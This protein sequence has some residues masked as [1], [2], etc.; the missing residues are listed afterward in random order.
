MFKV[1]YGRTLMCNVTWKCGIVNYGR[2]DHMYRHFKVQTFSRV[3]ILQTN[4]QCANKKNISIENVI[5]KGHFV[6]PLI[7]IQECM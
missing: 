1:Y 2:K 3:Q 7:K 4:T 5:L 6:A